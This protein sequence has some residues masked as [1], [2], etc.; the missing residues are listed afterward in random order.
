[1]IKF[2]SDLDRLYVL[3]ALGYHWIEVYQY[4]NPN[5]LEFP[6]VGRDLSTPRKFTSIEICDIRVDRKLL[7]VGYKI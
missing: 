1:M 2:W 3:P 5:S 4:Y 6:R 7:F